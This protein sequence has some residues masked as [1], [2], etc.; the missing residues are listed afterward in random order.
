MDSLTQFALGAAL[1]GATLGPRAGRKALVWGG[2]LGTIPDLDIFIP[3]ADPVAAFTYH[4]GWTHS[5][6]VLTALA[7]LFASAM[8]RL[9]PELR[10]HGPLC[11][12]AAWLSL[13]TH[14][15]L[16]C[17]TVYGTQALQP[18]SDY[19]VAWATIFIIDPLYTLPLALGVAGAA[20]A[21]ARRPTLLARSCL[22]GL[23][24]SSG[25]LGWS[26]VAKARVESAAQFA[27]A[28]RGM[29]AARVLTQ[30]AAFNTLLWRILVIGP[31]SYWEGFYSVFDGEKKITLRE[32]ASRPELLDGLEQE[33]AV[34]RLKWFTKGFYRVRESGGG[35]VIT[36]LRMGVEPHYIFSFRVGERKAGRSVASPGARFEPARPDRQQLAWIWRRIWAGPDGVYDRKVR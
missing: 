36:D 31:D 4:R 26:L 29:S 1:G 20:W 10:E 8:K 16:D 24:L 19:P 35:V 27:L 2:V 9:H 18:L 15:L 5:F 13:A 21:S 25:Y 30:P 12:L 34:A 33:W 23:L 3:Y 22:A 7:P 11:L 32:F 14:P 28:E 17:F 6:F